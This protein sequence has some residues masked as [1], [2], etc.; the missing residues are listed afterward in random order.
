[1]IQRTSSKRFT[2]KKKRTSY[3]F[4]SLTSFYR[5]NLITSKNFGGKELKDIQAIK[6]QID[7]DRVYQAALSLSIVTLFLISKTYAILDLSYYYIFLDPNN[8]CPESLQFLPWYHHRICFFD[9]YHYGFICVRI[10]WSST[11]NCYKP[12]DFLRINILAYGN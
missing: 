7:S 11:K 9:S 6:D 3:L 2:P 12:K 5:Y 10:S 4:F 1:M 8:M